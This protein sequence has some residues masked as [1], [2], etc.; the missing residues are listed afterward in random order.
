MGTTSTLFSR[1][2]SFDH[3]VMRAALSWRNKSI[4]PFL[5]GI[6]VTGT[7][8]SWI[9]LAMALRLAA[10]FQIEFLPRQNELL[11][12]LLCPLIAW[13]TGKILKNYFKRPRP[14]NALSNYP[15]LTKNPTCHS[16][17]SSHAASTV[18]FFVALLL[19][20]HPFAPFVG[21]WAAIVSFSRLYLGV[22]YPT[23]IFVG[24]LIGISAGALIHPI[25]N[26]LNL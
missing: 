5:K 19:M 1:W 2:N 15:I 8:K 21:V 3:R 12:A 20:Q 4:T 9:A 17:P 13:L 14:A 18:S 25:L 26:L 16:F 7:Y 23:D 10:Y 22:H 11:T 6:T 24:I